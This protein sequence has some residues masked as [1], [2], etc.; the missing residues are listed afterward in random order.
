MK[1]N[2]ILENQQRDVQLISIDDFVS[3]LGEVRQGNKDLIPQVLNALLEDG[4]LQG[5]FLDMLEAEDKQWLLALD[6]LK[7]DCI[8]LAGMYREK[9]RYY[10]ELFTDEDTGEEVVIERTEL[11]E[12]TSWFEREKNEARALYG[13]ICAADLPDADVRMVCDW[14]DATPFNEM[15]IVE[16]KKRQMEEQ[17]PAHELGLSPLYGWICEVLGDAYYYGEEHCGYYIDIAKA[18]EYYAKA[19]EIK[20]AT[21][22]E[23]FMLWG[24]PVEDFD[25][26][27][28]E[29]DERCPLT[30]YYR[31][32]G[33]AE[34]LYKVRTTIDKL[35]EKYGMPGNEFG[36]YVPTPILLQTLLGIKS[37]APNY[38]GN[39]LF[40]EDQPDGTI[41][42][43]M[44]VEQTYVWPHVLEQVFPGIRVDVEKEL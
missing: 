24:N 39:L 40:M 44:E 7:A 28:W 13:K 23:T 37:K 32:S 36:R 15:A 35:T 6:N 42:L 29:D 38:W 9:C 17:V 4:D 5:K 33:P 43:T 16:K 22:D 11:I 10:D 1:E 14:V 8:V 12:G 27:D 2:N 41:F 34:V 26:K 31:L 19:Q 18:R 30:C 3:M 25:E 21:G 20:H